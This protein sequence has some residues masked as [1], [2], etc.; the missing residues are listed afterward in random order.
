MLIL[1]DFAFMDTFHANM[2]RQKWETHDAHHRTKSNLN[3]FRA[4][5]FTLLD[6]F[7]EDG[8][9]PLLVVPVSYLL[10][11]NFRVHGAAQI[12]CLYFDINIHSLNIHSLVTLNPFLQ[13]VFHFGVSHQLHHAVSTTNF[14]LWPWAHLDAKKALRDHKMLQKVNKSSW[15]L[16]FLE[17]GS[18]AQVENFGKASMKR[19]PT[20]GT[21]TSQG[22]PPA[23]FE[24]ENFTTTG[25]PDTDFLTRQISAGGATTPR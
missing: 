21:E 2:H 4:M 15:D 16:S 12:L 3:I 18:T 6:C 24:N 19:N 22:L 14:M 17:H 20:P 23:A 8:C 25:A 1:K 7:I 9:A 5:N 13:L 11:G 10:T